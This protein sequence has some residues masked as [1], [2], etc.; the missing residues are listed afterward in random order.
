QILSLSF[1][2]QEK[3]GLLGEYADTRFHSLSPGDERGRLMLPDVDGRRFSPLFVYTIYPPTAP[4]WG[5]R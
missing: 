4:P 1:G 3:W 2:N 5:P